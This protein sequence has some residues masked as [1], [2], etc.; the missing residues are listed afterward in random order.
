[1]ETNNN[2]SDEGGTIVFNTSQ[3]LENYLS[4]L[5]FDLSQN[6]LTQAYQNEQRKRKADSHEE[7][8]ASKRVVLTHNNSDE[9]LPLGSESSSEDTQRHVDYLRNYDAANN[10][11]DVVRANN[12]FLH[13]GTPSNGTMVPTGSTG[14]AINPFLGNGTPSNGTMVP[15][16]STGLLNLGERNNP[17]IE[18]Q[19]EFNMY[20]Q[21]VQNQE[22]QLYV[23]NMMVLRDH[24][25]TFEDMQARMFLGNDLNT[26]NTGINSSAP[27]FEHETFEDFETQ[28]GYKIHVKGSKKKL[29]QLVRKGNFS[30]VMKLLDTDTD[31]VVGVQSFSDDKEDAILNIFLL[32]KMVIGWYKESTNKVNESTNKVNVLYNYNDVLYEEI[33]ENE[34]VSLSGKGKLKE[35]DGPDGP[36]GPKK[37]LLYKDSPINRRFLIDKQ[38]SFIKNL[39]LL[40]SQTMWHTYA[41]YVLE[42]ADIEYHRNNEGGYPSFT[43]CDKTI[44]NDRSRK[45]TKLHE[46]LSG[47]G[48]QKRKIK[49][50]EDSKESET[51]QASE[52]C[53]GRNVEEKTLSSN[54]ELFELLE[55]EGYRKETKLDASRFPKIE[56]SNIKLFRHSLLE[57]ACYKYKQKTTDKKYVMIKNREINISTQQKERQCLKDIFFLL[58]LENVDTIFDK[59]LKI[60]EETLDLFFLMNFP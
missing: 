49:E 5:D 4:N 11:S 6:D 48:F 41:Y 18:I 34:V 7:E 29:L 2:H 23:R 24:Q 44:Q 12:S 52:K 51:V 58:G 39:T 59:N 50:S 57:V 14:T 36:K 31:I 46:H 55:Q 28:D 30:K 8:N 3:V 21:A 1:M 35:N 54:D 22:I 19:N 47:V 56:L 13:N 9:T 33:H 17:V 37:I 45:N 53:Y 40:T 43:S 26:A 38:N 32:F 10:S 15:T 27:V 20:K 25:R 42:K 60:G 16:G